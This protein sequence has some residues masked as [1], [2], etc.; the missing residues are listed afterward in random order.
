MTSL[1]QDIQ[2][3]LKQLTAYEKIIA[4][5]IVVFFINWRNTSKI[6][7]KELSKVIST[8]NHLFYK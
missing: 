5:N 6:S 3:K 7:N 4:I 2:D 1:T 8:I